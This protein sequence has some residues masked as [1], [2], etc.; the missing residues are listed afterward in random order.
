MTLGFKSQGDMAVS[1][2]EG[3]EAGEE[4]KV[5]FWRSIGAGEQDE[6]LC[7]QRMTLDKG[8]DDSV[9]VDLWLQEAL[10]GDKT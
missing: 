4:I 2:I 6:N 1:S 3:W 5:I 7:G 10:S 8:P 9:T